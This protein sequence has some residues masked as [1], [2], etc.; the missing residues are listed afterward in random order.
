M[1][2]RKSAKGPSPMTMSPPALPTEAHKGSP[3]SSPEPETD[4]AAE[5]NAAAAARP[6]GVVAAAV[7]AAALL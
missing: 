7:A 6:L 4:K 5:K 3:A 1:P 2:A